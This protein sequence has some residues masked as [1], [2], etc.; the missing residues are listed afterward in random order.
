M[1]VNLW[2]AGNRSCTPSALL[3][4]E[5]AVQPLSLTAFVLWKE[6]K[7]FPFLAPSGL[8]VLGWSRWPASSV[9]RGHCGGCCGHVLSTGLQSNPGTALC[10]CGS[11]CVSWACRGWGTECMCMYFCLEKPEE[12][13]ASPVSR[14]YKT[15][16]VDREKK[17]QWVL[18]LLVWFSFLQ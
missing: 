4:Q 11:M 9:L 16:K 1:S 10:I 5:P 15:V 7:T 17:T 14:D 8:Q 18:L 3:N 12:K 2:R 13:C 6:K